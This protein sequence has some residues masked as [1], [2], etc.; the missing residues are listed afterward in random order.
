MKEQPASGPARPHAVR[1]L[2]ALL[3]AV[4]TGGCVQLETVID[5]RDDGSAV[6][7]ERLL[8]SNELQ[9]LSRALAPEQ[10][11]P[12]HLTRE[13]ALDRM[14][15]MGDGVRLVSHQE[16]VLTDGSRQSLAVF[17]ITDV[18]NLRLASPFLQDRRPSPLLRLRFSPVYSSNKRSEIGNVGV[19]FVP[20]GRSGDAAEEVTETAADVMTTPLDAQRYREL[21]PIFSD[22]L[23]GFKIRVSLLVHN[24]P[25]QGR[26]Q[27]GDQEIV[28]LSLSSQDL[29]GNGDRFL[30]NE[31]A[32]LALLRFDFKNPAI[33]RHTNGFDKNPHV[34]VS[35]GRSIY[36]S[37]GFSIRPTR[38]LYQKYFAGQPKS[39]GGD[40]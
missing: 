6:V 37:T 29:D 4:L 5:L 11:L 25:T 13:A 20:A 39:R 10:A 32:M 30:E 12:R 7:T 17:E 34:P 14:A 36:G 40:Q 22:L 24:Q 26:R 31:E 23:T 19:S 38:H 8:L 1:R 9:D 28:L 21:R 2:A 15:K 33:T 16:S 3:A 18:E 35:R 27:A